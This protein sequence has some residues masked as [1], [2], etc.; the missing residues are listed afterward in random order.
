MFYPRAALVPRLP[1]AGLSQAVGLTES[2]LPPVRRVLGDAEG[3]VEKGL[4][5][6]AQEQFLVRTMLEPLDAGEVE[7]GLVNVRLQY[8]A[9]PFSKR[10]RLSRVFQTLPCRQCLPFQVELLR[11]FFEAQS[12]C[13][14]EK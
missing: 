4:H 11:T 13:R 2:I 14:L 7:A 8:G 12:G 10:G 6:R 5:Q 9:G 3:V 1:W